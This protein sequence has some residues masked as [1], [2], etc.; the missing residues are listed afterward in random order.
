LARRVGDILGRI[1]Y[2][3]ES[4]LIERN[5]TPIARLIPTAQGARGTLTDALAAWGN[6]APAD[7]SFGD[8]LA[9]VR[10][11]DQ[12]PSAAWDS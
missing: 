5:G 11:S 4:F 12:P 7:P 6:A 1:R 9:G 10:A 8:D 3:R 2:R